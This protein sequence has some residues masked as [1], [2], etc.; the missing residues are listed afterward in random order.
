MN[1]PAA[2]RQVLSLYRAGDGDGE[3]RRKDESRISLFDTF[4][5]AQ[6]SSSR[7]ENPPL[8]R[9]CHGKPPGTLQQLQQL[10]QGFL[11]KRRGGQGEPLAIPPQ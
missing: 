1:A 5:H 7:P 10:A 8:T 9:N 11:R 2:L 4:V 6:S 3:L